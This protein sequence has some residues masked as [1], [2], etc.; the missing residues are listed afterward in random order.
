MKESITQMC[1]G[2]HSRVPT[3]PGEIELVGGHSQTVFIGVSMSHLAQESC[4]PRCDPLNS[5]YT[6]MDI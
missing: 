4:K 2:S 3:V 5:S 1:N 6:V